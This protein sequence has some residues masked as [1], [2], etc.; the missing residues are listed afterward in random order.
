MGRPIH[1][2]VSIEETRG[3]VNKLIKKF[4]KKVKKSKLLDKLRE[5]RFYEKPSSKRRRSLLNKRRNAQK[6]ER[7]RQRKF[8][9][10]CNNRVRR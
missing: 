3:D 7:D 2:E 8:D 4:V 5:N 1:V 10:K 9:K 6:A